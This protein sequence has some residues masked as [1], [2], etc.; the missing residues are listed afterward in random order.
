MTFGKQLRMRYPYRSDIFTNAAQDRHEGWKSRILEADASNLV[1]VLAAFTLEQEEDDHLSMHVWQHVLNHLDAIMTIIIHRH[2]RDLLLKVSPIRV[3][4]NRD[5]YSDSTDPLRVNTGLSVSF[6]ESILHDISEG[7]KEIGEKIAES[8]VSESEEVLIA[9]LQWLIKF[10]NKCEGKENLFMMDIILALLWAF[11]DDVAGYALEVCAAMCTEPLSHRSRCLEGYRCWFNKADRCTL[12][13]ILDVISAGEIYSES[14]FTDVKEFIYY[15]DTTSSTNEVV[16]IDID[17]TT[18]GLYRDELSIQARNRLMEVTKDVDLRD[19]SG[20]GGL[21]EIMLLLKKDMS[22]PSLSSD[23][24]SMASGIMEDCLGSKFSTTATVSTLIDSHLLI[25]MWRV[26]FQLNQINARNSATWRLLCLAHVTTIIGH[27]EDWFIRTFYHNKQGLVPLACNVVNRGREILNMSST[28]TTESQNQR[29][30]ADALLWSTYVLWAIFSRKY[31]ANEWDNEDEDMEEEE[32]LLELM[33]PF[34]E[35]ITCMGLQKRQTLG[36]LPSLLLECSEFLKRFP[37]GSTFASKEQEIHAI[38][39]LEFVERVLLIMTQSVQLRKVIPSLVENGVMEAFL[40]VLSAPTDTITE[41]LLPKDCS[42]L[43]C[44]SKVPAVPQGAFNVIRNGIDSFIAQIVEWILSNKFAHGTYKALNGHDKIVRRLHYEATYLGD[45]FVNNDDTSENTD[46]ST[47]LH[48]EQSP[49]RHCVDAIILGLVDILLFALEHKS[50]AAEGGQ[51]MRQP[52]LIEAL[53]LI[54]R[55]NAKYNTLVLSAIISFVQILI[56]EDPAPPSNLVHLNQH[57]ILEHMWAAFTA[58]RVMHHGVTIQSMLKLA[59][60]IAFHDSGCDFL[61][62]YNVISYIVSYC[63][64]FSIMRSESSLFSTYFTENLGKEL[65]KLANQFHKKVSY[66]DSVVGALLDQFSYIID[67]GITNDQQSFSMRG[68]MMGV[69]EFGYEYDGHLAQFFSG[70]CNVIIL[71]LNNDDGSSTSRTVKS[72]ISQEGLRRLLHA[73]YYAHGSPREL[74]L[75]TSRFTDLL[76]DTSATTDLE[77]FQTPVLEIVQMLRQLNDPDEDSVTS[78]LH[79]LIEEWQPKCER[80]IN[81]LETDILSL[82]DSPDSIARLFRGEGDN[83][84]V[85]SLFTKEESI[86]QLK[87]QDKLEKN[88]AVYKCVRAQHFL[89]MLLL[90]LRIDC[91]KFNDAPMQGRGINYMIKIDGILLRVIPLVSHL[92][93]KNVVPCLLSRSEAMVTSASGNEG[94][95]SIKGGPLLKLF[96]CGPKIKIKESADL[97]SRREAAQPVRHKCCVYAKT[98]SFVYDEDEEMQELYELSTGGWVSRTAEKSNG[99]QQVRV[100]GIRWDHQQNSQGAKDDASQDGLATYRHV[101]KFQSL[102][103]VVSVRQSLLFVSSK[104]FQYGCTMMTQSFHFHCNALLGS[105]Y[106]DIMAG[107]QS[108]HTMYSALVITDT[109]KYPLNLGNSFKD[110][111]LA[112]HPS[113]SQYENKRAFAVDLQRIAGKRAVS[114]TLSDRKYVMQLLQ[115]LPFPSASD[116]TNI[117]LQQLPLNDATF[118]F[119]LDHLLNNLQSVRLWT[120]LLI[121]DKYNGS[122]NIVEHINEVAL[123]RML[124]NSDV[125]DPPLANDS[126]SRTSFVEMMECSVLVMLACFPYPGAIN[127]DGDTKEIDRKAEKQWEIRRSAALAGVHEVLH[128]WYLL[129]KYCYHA[130]LQSGRKGRLDTTYMDHFGTGPTWKEELHERNLTAYTEANQ[131]DRCKVSLFAARYEVL[132]VMYRYLNPIFVH[133]VLHAL[134]KVTVEQITSCLVL[135]TQISILYLHRSLAHLHAVT[136]AE[137]ESEDSDRDSDGAVA[138]SL[139]LLGLEL[140]VQYTSSKVDGILFSD[141]FMD[142]LFHDKVIDA[143]RRLW[144]ESGGLL[145]NKQKDQQAHDE[146]GKEQ[147][148]LNNKQSS[149]KGANKKGK[150]VEEVPR[151]KEKTSGQGKQKEWMK[152]KF[153]G[154]ANGKNKKTNQKKSGNNGNSNNASDNINIGKLMNGVPV[155]NS[156]TNT[157]AFDSFVLEAA[158]FF[159]HSCVAIEDNYRSTIISMSRHCMSIGAGFTRDQS[160]KT[161]APASEGSKDDVTTTHMD[162]QWLLPVHIR[163]KQ[164]S[165]FEES[166]YQILCGAISQ[167]DHHK[168]IPLGTLPNFN[169]YFGSMAETESDVPIRKEE[170]EKEQNAVA[171]REEKRIRFILS[172]AAE[173]AMSS[174]INRRYHEEIFIHFKYR[175]VVVILSFLSNEVRRALKEYDNGIKEVEVDLCGL[176]KVFYML[177]SRGIEIPTRETNESTYVTENMNAM[178]ALWNLHPLLRPLTDDLRTFFSVQDS[179]ITPSTANEV[180]TMVNLCLMALTRSFIWNANVTRVMISLSAIVDAA[181]ASMQC[182]DFTTSVYVRDEKLHWDDETRENIERCMA[183]FDESDDYFENMHGKMS[184]IAGKPPYLKEKLNDALVVSP[185]ARAL[186]ES[187]CGHVVHAINGYHNREEGV[188]E[189]RNRR[190]VQLDMV[191]MGAAANLVNNLGWDESKSSN[192]HTVKNCLNDLKFILFT[193]RSPH[194]IMVYHSLLLSPRDVYIMAI[195]CCALCDQIL[196]SK[197]GCHQ[198]EDD[199][200]VCLQLLLQ[201][202]KSLPSSAR[203]QGVVLPEKFFAKVYSLTEHAFRSPTSFKSGNLFMLTSSLLQLV[204]HHYH[205][206]SAPSRKRPE[207]EGKREGEDMVLL[208]RAYPL[209]CDIF[210]SIMQGLINLSK[211]VSSTSPMPSLGVGMCQ[212]IYQQ[213]ETIFERDS[214][215][216]VRV[217]NTRQVV[218]A[219]EILACMWKLGTGSQSK[220]MSRVHVHDTLVHLRDEVQALIFNSPADESVSKTSISPADILSDQQEDTESVLVFSAADPSSFYMVGEHIGALLLRG[221]TRFHAAM[222]ASNPITLTEDQEAEENK[223]EENASALDLALAYQVLAVTDIISCLTGKVRESVLSGIAA[224]VGVTGP[225]ETVN[226]IIDNVVF[227]DICKLMEGLQQTAIEN[228]YTLHMR[229]RSRA[230]AAILTFTFVQLADNP[231]GPSDDVFLKQCI[232]VSFANELMYDPQSEELIPSIATTERTLTFVKKVQHFLNFIHL[233]ST[234]FYFGSRRSMYV[235]RDSALVPRVLADSN[236]FVGL[237]NR[238]TLSLLYL[239][240]VHKRDNSGANK[241]TI[242]YMILNCIH[243]LNNSFHAV[244]LELSNRQLGCILESERLRPSSFP[245]TTPLEAAHNDEDVLEKTK[246]FTKNL[247][248][249]YGGVASLDN[250]T[251]NMTLNDNKEGEGGGGDKS[252][253]KSSDNGDSRDSLYDSNDDGADGSLKVKGSIRTTSTDG[254][255][256]TSNYKNE[257]LWALS[258][259]GGDSLHDY[260]DSD[261]YSTDETDEM[262]KLEE[263]GVHSSLGDYVDNDLYSHDSRTP[264]GSHSYGTDDTVDDDMEVSNRDQVDLTITTPRVRRRVALTQAL[265][266]RRTTAGVPMRA[267]LVQSPSGVAAMSIV[268]QLQRPREMEQAMWN[269]RNPAYGMSRAL[270]GAGR[271]PHYV[272][273]APQTGLF[274]RET[275]SQTEYSSSEDEEDDETDEDVSMEDRDT[276]YSESDSGSDLSSTGSTA[277]SVMPEYMYNTGHDVVKQEKE[278]LLSADDIPDCFNAFASHLG[279]VGIDPVLSQLFLSFANN[280]GEGSKCRV[281]GRNSRF[282][283]TDFRVQSSFAYNGF[284]SNLVRLMQVGS[285]S[286]DTVSRGWERMQ[287]LV[288]SENYQQ[289]RVHVHHPERLATASVTDRLGTE[290][291]QRQDKAV[292]LCLTQLTIL[293]HIVELMGEDNL[294]W[295]LLDSI[296]SVLMSL[297]AHTQFHQRYFEGP[298]YDFV[299]QNTIGPSEEY[300]EK[301]NSRTGFK[302]LRFFNETGPISEI[303]RLLIHQSSRN[304]ALD[305]LLDHVKISL[306]AGDYTSETALGEQTFAFVKALLERPVVPEPKENKQELQL[307]LL[308][309][310]YRRYAHAS[311]IYGSGHYQYHLDGLHQYDRMLVL[312]GD[313]LNQAAETCRGA[314]LTKMVKLVWR[315]CLL[316]KG[317]DAIETQ[318]SYYFPGEGKVTKNFETG[319]SRVLEGCRQIYMKAE[320][321]AE[322]VCPRLQSILRYY[323]T[324]LSYPILQDRERPEIKLRKLIEILLSEFIPNTGASLVQQVNQ[325]MGNILD[326]LTAHRAT[327]SK[328]DTREDA[329]TSLVKLPSSN[330]EIKLL[331]LMELLKSLLP[332]EPLKAN[333][334]DEDFTVGKGNPVQD[335]DNYLYFCSHDLRQAVVNHASFKDILDSEAWVRLR[336]CLKIAHSIETQVSTGRVM[337]SKSVGNGEEEVKIE[338]NYAV[339]PVLMR[340]FPAIECY[341]NVLCAGHNIALPKPQDFDDQRSIETEKDLGESIPGIFGTTSVLPSP[342]L[343][344]TQRP[345]K[346][347]ATGTPAFP[348]APP[349]GESAVLTRPI[350]RR[351]LTMPGTRFRCSDRY[352]VLHQHIDDV[353]LL[354]R[355]AVFTE[356]NKVILNVKLRQHIRLLEGSMTPLLVIPEC[357]KFLD[358]RVRKKYFEMRIDRMVHNLM[359][360]SSRDSYDIELDLDVDRDHVVESS[361]EGLR[362][363]TRVD[364]LTRELNISFNGE[365]GID[366]GGL[367]REWYTLL[368]RELFQ[369]EYAL[370]TKTKDGVTFQPDPRSS[371]NEQHLEYFRFVGK[372]MGKALLEKQLM[373]VHFTRSFY[374]HVLGQSV[375]F[376]DLE[377][378]DPEYHKNLSTLLHHS[379]EDLG[380]DHLTFSVDGSRFGEQVTF[381]LVANGQDIPVTDDNKAEYLRLLA[382]HHLTSSVRE[383]LG[384]FLDGFHELIPPELVSI[385]NAQEL[386]LLVCGC[387]YIDLDDMEANTTYNNY[388]RLDPTIQALWNVLRRFSMEEKAKFLSFVT[389]SSKVPLE[390]FSH[391]QGHEGIQRLSIH[392]AFDTSLLPTCHTCFNQLDLPDYGNEETL[393]EK[394]MIAL[395]LGNVGFG[396][397]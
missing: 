187:F 6:D 28:A 230:A 345:T 239:D 304:Q 287:A 368:S 188:S 253:D 237:I 279:G 54:L 86:R 290:I 293:V 110:V 303:V 361:M 130:V 12:E 109:L 132:R 340:F 119:N 163:E 365:E 215:M 372:L 222:R 164:W 330:A 24:K 362:Y 240:R 169:I 219:M 273:A 194:E 120:D 236:V 116:D 92:F 193:P 179:T 391:L 50:M 52:E 231:V 357:R 172:P 108:H 154:A 291:Q 261:K 234:P 78:Q 144:A 20:K 384:A 121:G 47:L 233:V 143:R 248:N 175:E 232:E 331:H 181:F 178:V 21:Q 285:F 301:I 136:R 260:S 161:T 55:T 244:A 288:T 138:V 94:D 112:S 153:A 160:K 60:S 35:M 333:E 34:S 209:A 111:K 206:S 5:F 292:F 390:G 325:D 105:T 142:S 360:R 202:F 216:L 223:N 381:D 82:D 128:L 204:S 208:A 203:T 228:A 256:I 85:S 243:N 51:S 358:F 241:G 99:Y 386:E 352:N 387:P 323:F 245:S 13:P 32:P 186:L 42:K 45:L 371:V 148:P 369:S 308:A 281:L 61:V 1:A 113:L 246:G 271:Q 83:S 69:D 48:I 185:D 259:D 278:L 377:S 199:L 359:E 354:K 33:E 306:E 93:T 367:T 3:F 149:K 155:C 46:S 4:S 207:G 53:Q 267:M 375:G 275:D 262:Y 226:Y 200:Q 321:D 72:F 67:V 195:R 190:I 150:T 19:Y 328:E 305:L 314:T 101:S 270:S 396:F 385:F 316:Y 210:L 268:N 30:D 183:D 147:D 374:K 66:T 341:L 269:D 10:L 140:M 70:L 289:C 151:K 201:H 64:D 389:G 334:D 327:L 247:K 102:S 320:V 49:S 87:E 137:V 317:T 356:E 27:P 104:L 165:S 242:S 299:G 255:E 311:S 363:A 38:Q 129:L 25:L 329:T 388:S 344:P 211:R 103:N 171:L 141:S 90:G 98:R 214:A 312:C 351:E 257:E 125:V 56:K 370:F 373:D 8:G 382:H 252:T 235:A 221:V 96:M 115:L 192:K 227:L 229:S 297:G 131:G 44:S 36:L 348:P 349:G 157:V 59:N 254:S 63:R 284:I 286:P 135:S 107:T 23:T 220:E 9:I 97:T 26:R 118:T 73:C 376:N 180:Q 18:A 40:G 100:I 277:D 324:H 57:R 114:T 41:T 89:M 280:N 264:S 225:F 310:F 159:L 91:N 346:E 343:T 15:S 353:H 122:N 212:D 182:G 81:A 16:R 166:I 37:V 176:L 347:T 380:M 29:I 145:K 283:C 379:L 11:D 265:T 276:E 339:S 378:V 126:N 134:P 295:K 302:Y 266:P 39:S 79:A 189:A 184:I 217:T 146:V 336:D 364:M 326:T 383:Q 117:F 156:V 355:L 65:R 95:V 224:A 196:S 395:D 307:L 17:I 298:A 294:V 170:E 296:L 338:S 158:C 350:L 71:L 7:S 76:Y 133:P 251:Q 282:W 62:K 218:L 139:N 31:D 74:L 22:N 213:F 191:H 14:L 394:L 309:Q 332:N 238:T 322:E 43:E 162:E 127:Q 263:D 106:D 393:R 173:D 84:T 77:Y 397:S 205:S 272:V 300:S 124:Y 68:T 198:L 249:M 337:R 197:K 152:H 342:P 168:F 88:R 318:R 319:L 335:R 58:G 392:K 174:G 2:E 315:C 313:I 366:A 274:A 258:S 167:V 177:M 75:L 250:M 123:V 80:D